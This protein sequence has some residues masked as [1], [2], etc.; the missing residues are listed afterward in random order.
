MNIIMTSAK[1]A[2]LRLLNLKL[3]AQL[4]NQ[5]LAQ[6]RGPRDHSARK[7]RILQ[8]GH[9]HDV[10]LSGVSTCRRCLLKAIEI[11][12]ESLDL[13]GSKHE[14]GHAASVHLG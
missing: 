9:G 12:A 6:R 3:A 4:R 14:V 1:A 10:G 7:E 5:R 13:V 11:A 2:R 8:C